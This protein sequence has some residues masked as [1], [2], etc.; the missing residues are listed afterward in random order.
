MVAF[1]DPI[2][3]IITTSLV[4][5]IAAWFMLIYGYLLKRK[6][7]YRQHGLIMAAALISHLMVIFLVMIPSFVY[8]ILPDYIQTS[9]TEAVSI[10]GLIHGITGP[11]TAAL[12]IWLVA[13]WHFN[14]DVASCFRRKK[15]MITT[16]TL[17]MI[18][19]ILGVILYSLL[20]G[21]LLAS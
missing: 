20:I 1:T 8:S 15:V 4:V 5:Q 2:I 17:W 18:T 14:K 12:G 13:A 3:L 19:L 9:P 10:V 16:I 11:L 7:K 6:Q 21:P